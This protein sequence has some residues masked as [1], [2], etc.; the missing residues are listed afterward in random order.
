MS[1]Q[2]TTA[3]VNQFSANVQMLSQQMGSLL[4]DTVDVETITGE[5]AF[6]EQIG[7]AAAV[8]RTS[9][10]ADTPIMDTPHARRMV[11]MRDFEYSDLIDDQDRIRTLIDPTSSYSKAAAAAIGRKM[12]DVIIA[13]M[14]GDAFTG[15]S[16]GTTVALPSTQKIAHGSAGLTIAKLL[17]SKKKLDA[18]SVDPSITRYFV[19]SP[20]QIEDLLGTTQVTSSDFNTVKALASGQV[21]SFM[22][23]KF[24]T[25]N[26]LTA[27]GSNRLC[28]AWAEDG[29][30]LAMGKEPKARIEERADKSFA[31]QVY[32]CASFSAVR[33]EEVKVVE[34]ACAE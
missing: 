1:T 29:I 10:H 11:T 30:K 34:V 8:E 19:C 24:I 25:S 16:G 27:S 33:M 7:S 5:K 13:A 20:D 2:I 15:S 22:G 28:Y 9:R 4:R 17:E 3:F 21:D 12:D 23:F 14:G 6:F 26:R 32:Y 31:T 18:Q